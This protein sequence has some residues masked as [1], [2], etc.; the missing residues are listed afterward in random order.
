MIGHALSKA[1][2]FLEMHLHETKR[3]MIGNE[4]LPTWHDCFV[5]VV[6]YLVLASIALHIDIDTS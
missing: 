1:L 5:K 6:N 2:A 3:K 4:H